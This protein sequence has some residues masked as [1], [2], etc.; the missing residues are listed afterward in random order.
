MLQPYLH[1]VDTV[2]ETAL[3]HFAGQFSHAIRKGPLLE[4]GM[5]L[6]EGAYKEETIEPREPGGAERAVAAAVLDA[7]PR[8]TARVVA[9]DLLYARVDVVPDA[10]GAPVL[11]ELE[12]T[13]PSMFLVHDGADGAEAAGRFA[14][15]IVASLDR[16]AR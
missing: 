5:A 1:Q 16:V 7:M 3:L 14:D 12:L 10:G 4:V 11:L 6:V 9:D 15:A 2:G 13:E 8:T